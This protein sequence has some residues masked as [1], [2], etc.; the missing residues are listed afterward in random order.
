MFLKKKHQQHCVLLSYCD[1]AREGLPEQAPPLK[2]YR[3]T[4]AA[5]C[6]HFWIHGNWS[7]ASHPKKVKNIVFFCCFLPMASKTIVF[8]NDLALI[9]SCLAMQDRVPRDLAQD[10]N[11]DIFAPLSGRGPPEEARQLKSLNLSK[12]PG[13][14]K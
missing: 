6:I 11:I 1:M 2:K 3:S 12:R 4:S 9:P 8:Y 7:A 14:K 13:P 5:V 10:G